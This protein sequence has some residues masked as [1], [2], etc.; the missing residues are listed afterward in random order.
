MAILTSKDLQV[1]N[2]PTNNNKEKIKQESC[3]RKIM[4]SKS[5]FRFSPAP[6]GK[7]TASMFFG[8]E[9]VQLKLVDKMFQIPEKLKE[10]EKIIFIENLIKAGFEEV[11]MFEDTGE[12]VEKE[13]VIES[14]EWKFS[15]PDNSEIERIEGKVFVLIGGK[16]KKYKCEDGFVVVKT[17]AEFE[18]FIE[19]RWNEVVPAP[20]ITG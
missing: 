6:M 16:E 19:A 13:E 17:L 2:H 12:V 8:K 11:S 3:G 1:Q 7:S 20:I 5:I 10:P 18:A 9:E 14:T 4:K 15:H